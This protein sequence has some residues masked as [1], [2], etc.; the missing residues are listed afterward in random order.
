M[1]GPSEGRAVRGIHAR[2]AVQYGHLS[3]DSG[4]CL[5]TLS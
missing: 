3:G 5:R 4:A 1:I 2:G